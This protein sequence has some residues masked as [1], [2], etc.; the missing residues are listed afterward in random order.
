MQIKN[1]NKVIT[2]SGNTSDI[3]NVVM[4]AYDVESDPQIKALAEKLRGVNDVETCRN[5]WKYLIDNI[6]YKADSDGTKGELIKSP[7]RLLVDGTGDCKSYSLFTAVCLRWLGIPHFFRFASY[8]TKPEATHVYVVANNNIIIDA[9]STVQLNTDFNKEIKTT[10]HCDMANSGTRISYLAGLPK[11]GQNKS[12][13]GTDDSVYKVWIGDEDQFDITPGKAWLY[14][15]YDLL[16]EMINISASKAETAN[17]YDQLAIITAL[18]VQYNARKGNTT[19]FEYSVMIICGLIENGSFKSTSVDVDYRNF[20]FNNILQQIEYLYNEDVT[21]TAINKDWYSIIDS[22]VLENNTVQERPATVGNISGYSPIADVLKK[23]GIYF[24]YTF[25]PESELKDYPKVVADKRKT[26]SFFF[27][28]IEKIDIF[29][30][31]STVH[32]FFRSGIIARTGKQPEDYLKALK[33]ENVKVGSLLATLTLIST[34]IA[35]LLGLVELIKAIW[36]NSGVGKYA[37]SS[38]AAD[39]SKEVYTVQQKPTTT[40]TATTSGSGTITASTGL[41]GLGLLTAFYFIKKQNG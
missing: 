27:G 4:Y 18:L 5:I 41:L 21:P 23:A 19:D 13:K 14:G 17:L 39:L 10:Y 9:V 30:S 26:Q 24:I 25:I 38:G 33:T 16:S 22:E 8:S 32:G 7:A 1:I 29:H 40:P 31:R 15:Q 35:V 11:P 36:P 6:T 3:I 12:V 2:N 28:F 20:W 34:I 37:L